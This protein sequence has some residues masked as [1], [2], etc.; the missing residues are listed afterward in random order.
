MERTKEWTGLD[1][2]GLDQTG[3]NLTGNGC[4]GE[5][6]EGGLESDWVAILWEAVLQLRKSKPS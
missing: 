1:R 5:E 6:G 2:T 4:G 3:P